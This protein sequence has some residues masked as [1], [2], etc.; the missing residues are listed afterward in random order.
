MSVS[1]SHLMLSVLIAGHG[2]CRQLSKLLRGHHWKPLLFSESQERESD[3][4]GLGE[5]PP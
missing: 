2:H 1:C 3:W 5:G 4:A